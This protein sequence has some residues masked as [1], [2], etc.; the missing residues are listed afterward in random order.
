MSNA[1]ADVQATIEELWVYP[2]KS[3]AGVSLREAELTD[4]GLLYDRAWMVVDAQ[5]EFVSQRELPRMALIQPAFK[6]GQ[7]VLRAPGMLPLH[8]ALD[9]VESPLKVRVWDDEVQAWDMG[10]LAAQWF[11]DFLAPDAPPSLKRV[12]LARFDPEVKRPCDPAWTGGREA[13]TQFADGFGLRTRGLGAAGE[14][15]REACIVKL[16]KETVFQPAAS[17]IAV[18]CRCLYDDPQFRGQTCADF[19]QQL[20]NR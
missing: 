18:A 17:A 7:L 8:L 3:C 1:D 20:N 14:R 5:G 9:A 19:F 4:T 12:R 15:Q 13:T 6:M 10:D 2:I 16:A 11:S